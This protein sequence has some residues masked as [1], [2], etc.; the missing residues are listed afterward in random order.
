MKGV[1]P[2]INASQA[3]TILNRLGFR[4]NTAAR[5]KQSVRDFQGFWALGTAL[6]VDGLVGP[7]TAQALLWSERNR[8]AG[9]GTLSTNFSFSEFRCKCGGVYGSCRRIAGE[10]VKGSGKHVGRALVSSLEV[11]RKTVGGFVPVSGYR[12][13]SYNA[14]IGGARGSLHR[15][16]AACDT[17]QEISHQRVA[18]M[19]RFGGIGY[20]RS[21]GRVAHVDRRDLVP[22][23]NNGGSLRNP[24][25]W[26]YG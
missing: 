21:T 25:T 16:G 13:D 7:L 14:R 15:I 11:Y 4:T 1:K 22:G 9:R 26:I 19:H 12:C 23:W 6:K 10:G 5:Y 2:A 18:A 17:P 20:M 8:K 24:M 3:K